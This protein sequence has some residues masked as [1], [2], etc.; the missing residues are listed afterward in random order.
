MGSENNKIGHLAALFTVLIWGTTF[1]STKL[2][3]KSFDP[4]EIL[5][6]RFIIGYVALWIIYPK[7]FKVIN[8]K[9]ELLFMGAGL[10]GVTLYFLCEN[11]ALDITFASNVGV[12]VSIA[13]IFTAL[14]AHWFLEEETLK[15][16]FFLGF[17]TAILG[18]I[19]ISFT[20]TTKLQMNPLG[21]FLA[22]L[23]ALFWGAYSIFMKK[24]SN[25]GYATIG[26]TRKIFFYGI[27][28]MIPA[29]F[30]WPL[31]IDINTLIAPSNLIHIIFLGLGASATCYV[32]WN[33]ASKHLGAVRTS[34]YIYI[35]PVV[36]VIFSG[37]ILNETISF[38]SI[39][40]TLLTILGLLLSERKPSKKKTT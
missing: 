39:I 14:L 18:I 24:I 6:I 23:A 11:I 13:P 37:I 38:L 8:Q 28:F 17:I 30:F 15:P 27:L 20:S 26:A 21:D 16:T 25:L 22:V 32:T 2:L 40:G 33:L 31:S 29:L 5:L 36:T 4:L 3:L 35:I 10:C 7:G 1:I 9:H 19:L 12:I 34:V